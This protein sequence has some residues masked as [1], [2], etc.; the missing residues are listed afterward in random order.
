MLQTHIYI[1]T[2]NLD[3]YCR[4]RMLFA[5]RTSNMFW[6]KRK[7]KLV[8]CCIIGCANQAKHKAGIPYCSTYAQIEQQGARIAFTWIAFWLF[9]KISL[10]F[11]RQDIY[12]RCITWYIYISSHFGPVGKIV[13]YA[14]SILGQQY[15]SMKIFKVWQL[16]FLWR[17]LKRADNNFFSL[18]QKSW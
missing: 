7:T 11:C 5:Y 13:L 3:V 10:T 6:E 4:C 16:D 2:E 9:S 15:I 18:V 17:E 14:N 8:Q 1:V 12:R